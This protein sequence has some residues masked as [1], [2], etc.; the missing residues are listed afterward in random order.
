MVG[1]L[2]RMTSVWIRGGRLIDPH[3]GLDQPG[4]VHLVGGRIL[5]LGDLPKDTR[6]DQIVDARGLVV[7]P[8][9]VDL[10]ARFREPGL[11][12]KSTIARESVAAAAAGITTACQPPDGIPVTDTP[13]VA[14]LIQERGLETQNLRICPIGALTRGLM[15]R[16]LSEMRALKDAG[17]RAV[18]NGYQPVA[19]TLILRR[20]LEY[21]A[22]HDLLV[23]I[24]P[25]DPDLADGG[26]A[27]EGVIATRMGLRGIPNAAETVAVAKV[28]ALIE[29]TG[30]RVHFSL[31]SSA[32]ALRSI[33]RAQEKGL[34]VTA[35][36][37]A[38]YLHLTES[39]IEGFDA[40][41][42]VSPPFR[43]LEDRQALRQGVVDGV[44]AAVCSDHQPHDPDAKLDAFPATEPG[45]AALETLLPLMLELVDEGAMTLL[46][47]LRAL[48]VSPARIM[49]L[50][51]GR[52]GP[53][54]PADLV[55]FDPEA[56]WVVGPNSWRSQGQN[57]PWW[58][59]T[60]KGRVMATFLAGQCVFDRRGNGDGH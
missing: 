40:L 6:A 33:G 22:S 20:S 39:S 54:Q 7:C 4:D 46:T 17:C 5:A 32:R 41:C 30:A 59:K 58:G 35:D 15:G 14:Q 13:A 27:H 49:G 23:I 8:G 57:T 53:D 48:T 56:K 50:E 18:S 9:F 11:E 47:A 34:S 51:G 36:T 10:A 19:N 37:A 42:H 60:L 21:A 1:G 12:H 24:R 31:I 45:I 28:L 38:H 2:E 55:L 29:Q 26:C 44:I 52:L 43:T 3:S 25:E 16:D